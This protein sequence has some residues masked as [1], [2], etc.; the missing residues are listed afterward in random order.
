MKISMYR[1]PMFCL[2]AV[3]TSRV[4]SSESKILAA[5]RHPNS[6]PPLSLPCS[7]AY[8]SL[9]KASCVSMTVLKRTKHSPL[10]IIT[11]SITPMPCCC[12]CACVCVYM[13]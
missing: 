7:L 5:G 11:T 1:R 4:D 10:F 6:P 8:L 12:C 13:R 9:P 2:R 3:R